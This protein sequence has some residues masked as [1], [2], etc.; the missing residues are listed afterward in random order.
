[1][2][3]DL[4]AFY[5]WIVESCWFCDADAYSYLMSIAAKDK[6]ATRSDYHDKSQIE[7]NT[8]IKAIH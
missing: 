2:M 4:L 7:T 3:D 1:M 5:D 6:A 8:V